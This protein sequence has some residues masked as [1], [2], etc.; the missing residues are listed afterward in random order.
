MRVACTALAGF[1]AGCWR[2]GGLSA[3]WSARLTPRSGVRRS[4]GGRAAFA[5]HRCCFCAASHR[6][7]ARAGW[8][9]VARLLATAARGPIHAGLGSPRRQHVTAALS[10]ILPPSSSCSWRHCARRT[11]AQRW[12]HR[13]P[14]E[15]CTRCWPQQAAPTLRRRRRV[16]WWPPVS[17]RFPAAAA[18]ACGVLLTHARWGLACAP[19]PQAVVVLPPAEVV[20]LLRRACDDAPLADWLTRRAATNAALMLRFH[21]VS[22]QARPARKTCI[23]RQSALRSLLSTYPSAPAPLHHTSSCPADRQTRTRR[24]RTRR[25][26]RWAPA[27]PRPPPRCCCR[28]CRFPRSRRA[29]RRAPPPTSTSSRRRCAALRSVRP[30]W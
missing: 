20:A 12:R 25:A 2:A 17:L 14:R 15:R 5:A 29:S 11:C 13:H 28:R 26:R 7:D 1:P 24:Q 19:R 21:D 16:P 9:P 4:S 30:R 23:A 18:V 22:P 3:T 10:F 8:Q 27:T 6:H